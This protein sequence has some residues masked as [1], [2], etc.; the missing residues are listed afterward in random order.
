MGGSIKNVRGIET[1]TTN[2]TQNTWQRGTGIINNLNKINNNIN[3]FNISA[4]PLKLSFVV[5]KADNSTTK[6]YFRTQDTRCL[7]HIIAIDGPSVYLPNM[8]SIKTTHQ[9]LFP[10]KNLL[11]DALT[12]NILPNLQTA[13]LL[14]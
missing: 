7:K 5:A 8:E 4:V 6:H 10:F 11:A 12:A 9:G 3:S 2:T 14:P 1:A 13:S